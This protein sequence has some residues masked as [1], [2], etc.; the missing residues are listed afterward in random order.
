MTWATSCLERSCPFPPSVNSLRPQRKK[1]QDLRVS[2]P[3]SSFILKDDAR[4]RKRNLRSF[5]FRWQPRQASARGLRCQDVKIRSAE[6]GSVFSVHYRRYSPTAASKALLSIR[7][8]VRAGRQPRPLLTL[9]CAPV[10]R[11]GSVLCCWCLLNRLPFG[12][13]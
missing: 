8:S 2:A 13:G 7:N 10:R 5:I 1:I 9:I 6:R 11:C 3:I 12:S 4:R